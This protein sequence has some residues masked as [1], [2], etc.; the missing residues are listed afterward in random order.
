VPSDIRF[1]LNDD[2]TTSP[3]CATCGR[4]PATIWAARAVSTC[5]RFDLYANALA[6]HSHT[7]AYDVVSVNMPWLEFAGGAARALD[8]LLTDA[9]PSMRLIFTS[10]WDGN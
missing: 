8:D 9:R 5:P 6:G 2:T 3:R 7:P 10:V 4:I 1:L